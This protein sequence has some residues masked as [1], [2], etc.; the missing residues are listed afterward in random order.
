M[1]E[2]F[3]T[4]VL[5]E[6]HF[7]TTYRAFYY[8]RSNCIIKKP[9]RHRGTLLASICATTEL[10][11]IVYLVKAMAN[12]HASL[13]T[14]THTSHILTHTWHILTHTSPLYNKI[15]VAQVS[16]FLGGWVWGGWTWGGW[17]YMGVGPETSGAACCMQK[18]GQGTG[19][20]NCRGLH[21]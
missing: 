9:E 15:P 20:A 13:H 6:S 19:E 2:I 3:K 1:G 14:L 21:L 8:V 17:A 4:Y 11:V 7:I 18:V 12:H 5:F 16:H 10:E